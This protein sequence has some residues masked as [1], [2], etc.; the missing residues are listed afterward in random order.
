MNKNPPK[1]KIINQAIQ[2]HLEGNITEAIRYYQYC[3]NHGFNDAMV[4]SNY[5]VIL[6]NL[7]KFREAELSYRKAL[8]IKP[9]YAEAYS[10]LGN[11][12]SIKE[13]LKR[14]NC[15]F[16]SLKLN[17]TTQKHIPT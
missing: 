13:N 4:F 10:N 7:G 14:Q 16:E 15:L 6:Q 1:E 9:D 3:I 5:G 8:E 12:L 2:F 11:I 17:L